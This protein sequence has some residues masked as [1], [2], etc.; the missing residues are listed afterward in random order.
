M[1]KRQRM[2]DEQFSFEMLLGI[3]D[4]GNN[5]SQLLQETVPSS[6]TGDSKWVVTKAR[7]L[8]FTT[9]MP[10][11]PWLC[12]ETVAVCWL[13]WALCSAMVY[14]T[15]DGYRQTTLPRSPVE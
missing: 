15:I 10:Y 7:G 4:C 11:K 6:R 3:W 5:T 8:T 2:T 1:S 14:C 12:D 9:R 13:N